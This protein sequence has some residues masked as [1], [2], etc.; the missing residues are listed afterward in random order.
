M[1]EMSQ[2]KNK[3]RASLKRESEGERPGTYK[4][5]AARNRLRKRS[6]EGKKRMGVSR[7]TVVSNYRFYQV[8]LFWH[9]HPLKVHY[10]FLFNVKTQ[11]QTCS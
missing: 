6:H 11:N 3:K 1:K 8:G 10:F 2:E 4:E 7:N 5:K 9:C